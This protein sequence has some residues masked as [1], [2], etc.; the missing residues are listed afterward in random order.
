MVERL[1]D[2]G[3]EQHL[4]R[5]DVVDGIDAE[6][7]SPAFADAGLGRQMEDVGPVRQQARQDRTPGWST[8]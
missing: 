7:A 5:L 1:A 3:L 2:T 8:R 4:R 6:V